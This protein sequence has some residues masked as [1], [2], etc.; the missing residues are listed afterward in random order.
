VDKKFVDKLAAQLVK[1]NAHVWIDS[2]ELNVGDSILTHVQRA[3]EEA[4][5]LLIVLSKASVHSEWVTKELNAGLMR[6]LDEKRVLVLPVLLEDCRIPMFLR[7]KMYA[8]FRQNFDVG[9]KSLLDALLKV[10]N[11]DQGRVYSGTG[12]I[13]WSEDWGYE[14]E[15]LTMHYTLVEQWS[16]FPF[17]VLT[18][19]ALRCNDG[20]T[21]QY[22][23]F[24]EAGL[25]WMGRLFVTRG[26]SEVA[27]AADIRILLQ[28]QHPQ[29][30]T[31][32]WKNP[33]TG[34]QYSVAI[35]CRRL[36][37]D[38]GKDQLINVGNYLRQIRDYVQE[39]ARKPTAEEATRLVDL[40]A[41][42]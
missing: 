35:S 39:R 24:K 10:T 12:H 15:L 37:E 32:R 7:D 34:R 18:Q 40:A 38:N 36:G 13:D 8:D 31:R 22:E 25:E 3:I 9:L 23:K 28:D 11:L 1:N 41:G 30:D 19:V 21:R 27:A 26:L 33:T 5:A 6:E 16:K 17:V 2:W 20:L 42:F 14:G 29:T 4:S